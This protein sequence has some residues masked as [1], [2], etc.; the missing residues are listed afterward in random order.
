METQGIYEANS[1][2]GVKYYYK[3][4]GKD[5]T[6]IAFQGNGRSP[7]ILK[8]HSNMGESSE[9]DQENLKQI[10]NLHNRLNFHKTFDSVANV[11]LIKD[12]FL[13]KEEDQ[14][15]YPN[16][17]WYYK[18]LGHDLAPIIRDFITS[19]KTEHNIKT[20]DLIIIGSSKG[21]FATVNMAKYKELASMY[22]AMYPMLS[23]PLRNSAT[24]NWEI[25]YHREHFVLFDTATED[26][27]IFD[28][29][30]YFG[31]LISEIDNENLKII[32]GVNDEQSDLVLGN[33][34]IF[35]HNVL[36]DCSHKTHAQYVR[37]CGNIV[38]SFVFG[39]ECDAMDS[40]KE[41]SLRETEGKSSISNRIS[42][43]FKNR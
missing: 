2:I 38:K 12:D 15:K 14:I 11:L 9:L 18:A 35:K 34:D 13:I 20:E 28:P 39:I 33:S 22:I 40:I 3:D 17:F 8:L 24:R 30:K 10:K 27:L 43:W 42:S 1:R 31:R 4:N 36:L 6:I 25:N 19:F 5:K 16:V 32:V 7:E 21:A 37:E 26:E 29:I 23:N 41:V